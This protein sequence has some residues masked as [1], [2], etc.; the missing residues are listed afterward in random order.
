M[1]RRPGPRP[2]PS[3]LRAIEGHTK[4]SSGYRPDEAAAEPGPF[5]TP[6]WLG[7][8]AGAFFDEYAPEVERAGLLRPR[9]VPMYALGVAQFVF[10][11]RCWELLQDSPPLLKGRGD[12]LVSN[13]LARELRN[14]SRLALAF[15]AEFG[16]T[17]A[18]VTDLARRASDGQRDE[19]PAARLLS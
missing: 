18:A 9:Y 16:M 11:K 8:E 2:K 14:S 17:P 6:D 4:P 19:A 3:P 1:P 15:F 7:D 13:P 10:A 5:T 12:S